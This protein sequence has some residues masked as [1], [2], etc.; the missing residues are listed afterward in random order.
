[1]QLWVFGFT[2]QLHNLTFFCCNFSLLKLLKYQF[3][4]RCQIYKGSQVVTSFVRSFFECSY[5]WRLCHSWEAIGCDLPTHGQIHLGLCVQ[6][7][8]GCGF[9]SIGLSYGELFM[10]M[11]DLWNICGSLRIY[12]SFCFFFPIAPP[13]MIVRWKH[14]CHHDMALLC[15]DFEGSFSRTRPASPSTG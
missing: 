2:S 7:L 14:I 3:P 5:S 8:R 12:M 10:E 6:K 15:W 9:L 13:L 4:V 11:T 1:M